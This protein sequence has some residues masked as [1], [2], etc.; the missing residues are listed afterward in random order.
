VP[1]RPATRKI[2]NTPATGT[3]KKRN[4]G[5]IINIPIVCPISPMRD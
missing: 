3:N 4:T 2:A 1:I 5:S